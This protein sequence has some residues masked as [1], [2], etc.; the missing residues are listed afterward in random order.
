MLVLNVL[1]P[2]KLILMVKNY[3]KH[4]LGQIFTVSPPFDLREAYQ[5]TSSTTPII[6]I[7]SP[8]ADPM[9]YLMKLAQELEMDGPR[10]KPLS[11]GQGQGP[12]AK[13]FILSGRRNGDWVCL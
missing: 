13:E 5:D 10:F 4:T 8:G 1:R 6:F 2:E 3:V 11:L 7:L 9:N 12:I